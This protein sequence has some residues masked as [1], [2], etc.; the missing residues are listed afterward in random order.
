MQNNGKK[1][2]VRAL[3]HPFSASFQQLYSKIFYLSSE[4]ADIIRNPVESSPFYAIIS[5]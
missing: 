2:K 3:K 4:K 5:S 1:G